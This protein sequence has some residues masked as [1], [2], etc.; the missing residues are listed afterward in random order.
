AGRTRGAKKPGGGFGDRAA[1]SIMRQS[2]SRTST[3]PARAGGG[4]AAGGAS[5]VAGGGASV[6]GDGGASVAADGGAAGVS[7]R[8]LSPPAGRGLGGGAFVDG[9]ACA[10]GAV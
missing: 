5:V 6:A 1:A 2:D 8:S 10:G 7:V 4:A 9:S 3:F